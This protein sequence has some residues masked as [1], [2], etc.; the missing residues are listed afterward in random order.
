MNRTILK[1]SLVAAVIAASAIL[2]TWMRTNAHVAQSDITLGNIEAF[3]N[4]TSLNC[5]FINEMSE[6]R[7]YVGA[8]GKIKL[9][10]G[11]IIEAGADG[12]VS[13][14]GRVVCKANGDATCSPVECKD[15]YEVVLK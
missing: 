10:G 9:L 5:E 14:D 4:S 1:S 15:L 13:I 3:Q 12:Y 2:G 8:K 7:I 6:C 11:S